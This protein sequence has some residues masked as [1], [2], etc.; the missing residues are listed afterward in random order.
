MA[1]VFPSIKAARITKTMMYLNDRAAFL[2]ALR[3]D[4]ERLIRMATEREM[5]PAVRLNG[6]SDQPQLAREMAL[7]FPEVQFYDYTKVPAPWKR[8]LPNYHLTFSFS[9]EN[10]A[11]C[12]VALEH[13]INVAVVFPSPNFP[14]TWQGRPVV[15]GDASDL[16]FRDAQ[17]VIVGLKAKGD[18]RKLTAGG[19][20]QIGEAA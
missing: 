19:F 13:G 7:A 12:L 5:I 17:G 15:N 10:L 18:A 6:T 14:E 20:V 4:I 16:R 8:T 1:G 3:A 9:G 11:E 2:T